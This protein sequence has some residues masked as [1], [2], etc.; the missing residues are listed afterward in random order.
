MSDNPNFFTLA[1]S[2][3]FVI[4]DGYVWT[5]VDHTTDHVIRVGFNCVVGMFKS[6]P[7][8]GKEK[9]GDRIVYTISPG[10]LEAEKA[11]YEKETGKCH[12]CLGVGSALVGWSRDT[13]ERFGPC[14]DCNAT[15]RATIYA[16][17]DAARE[18]GEA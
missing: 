14:R 3:R 15:G 1:V 17:V 10:E 2:R 5:M 7:R 12:R 6:G 11:R 13:G 9:Y 8:K 16:V 4:P 18:D